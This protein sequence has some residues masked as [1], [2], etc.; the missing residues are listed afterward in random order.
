MGL[1]QMNHIQEQLLRFKFVSYTI[2][3]FRYADWLDIL[4][5]VV[6]LIAAAANGTGLPLMIIVFGDMTNSFK[7]SV[8]C[9]LAMQET[10]GTAQ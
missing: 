2:T 4:L 9:A 1:F 7:K 8:C 10:S 6:G 5:M 3:A